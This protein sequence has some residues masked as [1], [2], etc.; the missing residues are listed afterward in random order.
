MRRYLKIITLIG[1]LTFFVPLAFNEICGVKAGTSIGD[2][3]TW[4]GCV[5]ISLDHKKYDLNDNVEV[6]ISYG[7]AD[8]LASELPTIISHHLV[9]YVVDGS[10][11]GRNPENGIILYERN[12]TGDELLSD[13][14]K[15]DPGKWIFSRVKYNNNYDI[16]VYFSEYEFDNG[17]IYIKFYETF[18][19]QDNINDEL[20][21]TERTWDNGTRIYFIKNDKTIQFSHREF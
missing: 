10:Q 6:H 14:Q 18:I 8:Q 21:N 1:I 5:Q 12:I 13:D 17:V 7:H 16:S 3:T 11:P 20:V 19:D 4:S 9:V 2:G 15:C